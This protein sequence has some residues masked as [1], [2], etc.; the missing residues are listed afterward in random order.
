MK[1]IRL[2]GTPNEK[3][4]A[5]FDCR[6]RYIAY[7]GARG[8]G[9]SWALRRKLILMCLHYPGL[10]ALILRRSYPELRENHILPLLAEI[11]D[12][13][14]YSETQKSFLFPNGSRIRL[15]YCADEADV[16]QYQGQ[17]Y[18][19]IAIDEATQLTEYQFVTLKACLRGVNDR[20]KRM[21]LTCNPGGVGHAWVKRL[22]VD[23]QFR[24]EEDPDDYAFIPARVYDNRVLMEADPAYVKQLGS[25]PDALRRA[26]LEGEWDLFEGQFF[27]EF[28]R[29]L[30]VIEPKEIPPH[31]FHFAA[32][33]YGF[34]ML[35][36]VWIALDERGNFWVYRELCRPNL[37]LSQAAEAVAEA[38]RGESIAYIAASPDLW[39]RRQDSGYS[40]V[41]I[42]ER[43]GALPPLIRADDRRIIGWRTLREYLRPREDAPPRLRIF[44]HCNTLIRS[45]G[46]LL[47]DRRRTEDAASEPHEIT[48]APEALR[49]GVMSCAEQMAGGGVWESTQGVR[50]FLWD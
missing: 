25:L 27:P 21:Y 31:W 7:G 4:K 23:R 30:H 35:A 24:G 40:G 49:Y 5:F 26:W 50:D 17:E 22:F 1:E 43:Q 13:A 38:C 9:K 42:M 15:G 32:M 47:F 46:A 2:R 36:V 10:R 19:I 18:D 11:K 39:N 45:L 34:D 14:S 16:L 29:A 28:S 3:Q 6:A 12:L 33:D 37:T 8:G 20:P 48:H 41:E 44:S